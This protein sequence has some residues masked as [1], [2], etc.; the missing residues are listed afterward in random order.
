ML[1]RARGYA[2]SVA[3]HGGS[4]I[5]RLAPFALASLTCLGL[6]LAGGPAAQAAPEPP[7]APN[8]WLAGGLS[9]L[10]MPVIAIGAAGLAGTLPGGGGTPL[11]AV[12]GLAPLLTGTGQWYAGD[13]QRALWVGLGGEVV[14]LGTVGGVG[15][16][17][18]P[19][20]SGVGI[21]M[22]LAGIGAGTLYSVWA[23]YD[24]LQT[25]QRLAATSAP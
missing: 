11:L 25:A 21:V 12:L 15:L 20:D 17:A 22:G 23:G 3:P 2:A 8:P 9:L 24:A 14:M 5:S 7:T 6:A 10:T 18:K 16:L 13:R 19:G 4:A 1:E